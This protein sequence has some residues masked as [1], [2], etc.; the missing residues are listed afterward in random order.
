MYQIIGITPLCLHL[1]T[2]EQEL[3]VGI[4]HKENS[5]FLGKE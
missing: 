1:S 3:Q 2:A 5:S 4:I